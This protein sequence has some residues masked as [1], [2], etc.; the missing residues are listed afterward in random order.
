M[1]VNYEYLWI[2]IPVILNLARMSLMN[3]NLLDLE[4]YEFQS[5]RSSLLVPQG[6]L[7]HPCQSL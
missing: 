2:L 5:Y 6:T 3:L 7:I 4:S 1:E